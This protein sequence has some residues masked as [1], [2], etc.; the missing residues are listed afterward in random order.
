MAYENEIESKEE[1]W[2]KDLGPRTLGLEEG[3]GEIGDKQK[4][5]GNGGESKPPKRNRRAGS[6]AIE[7]LKSK[8]ESVILVKK[9]ELKIMKQQQQIEGE[10]NKLLAAQQAEMQLFQQRMEQQQQYQQQ[11]L[12]QQNLNTKKCFLL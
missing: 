11:Q 5:K 2:L 7:Y 1:Q 8:G 6:D 12:Y 9:E 10:R 3:Y 4:R